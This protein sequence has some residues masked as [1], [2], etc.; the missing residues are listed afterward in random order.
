MTSLTDW[1]KHFRRMAAGESTAKSGKTVKVHQYGGNATP[2]KQIT[3]A[4]AGVS[5]AKVK[6]ARKKKAKGARKKK[7]KGKVHKRRPPTKKKK[8]GLKKK[9]KRPRARKTI[10]DKKK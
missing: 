3:S 6:V 8:K 1:V 4:A 7:V 10:F 9:Q 5:R 2:I